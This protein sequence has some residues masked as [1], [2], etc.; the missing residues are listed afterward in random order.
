MM[1]QMLQAIGQYSGFANDGPQ[2]HLRKFLEVTSNF[3]IPSISDD[4]FKLR[5]V[6]SSRNM[7]DASSGGA[8]LSDSYEE[9]YKLIKSITDNTYQ[10][11]VSRVVP[12]PNQKKP[13]GVHEVTE[14][15]VLT[16]QIAQLIK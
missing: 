2:L 9:G 16:A 1:F 8:L 10:W 14:T 13:T 7:L 15:V 12:T 6:P 5:L 11:P 4:A 3:N